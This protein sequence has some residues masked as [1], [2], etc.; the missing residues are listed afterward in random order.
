MGIKSSQRIDKEVRRLTLE[1]QSRRKQLKLTQESFAEALD[2][3]VEAI[4]AIENGR[5]HPS[6]KMLIHIA[7]KLGLRVTL[8]Q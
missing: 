6:L 7:H 5:R 2:I 3:S 1:I 8:S 4:K